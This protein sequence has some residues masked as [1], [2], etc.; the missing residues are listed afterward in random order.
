MTVC[1]A[2]NAGRYRASKNPD[3]S[4]TNSTMCPSCPL[5]FLS[6]AGSTKC[7]RCGA[8]RY[9]DGCQNCAKGQYRNGSDPIATS[10]RNCPTGYYNGDVGQGACLPCSPGEYNNV[11]GAKA[12]KQ[13]S[14]STYFSGKGRNS[15][16]IDC[17]SGWLSEVGSVKCFACGAGTF[18][19]GCKHCPLGYARTGTTNS[20]AT[21]CQQCKLGETTSTT[22]AAS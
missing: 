18:G 15:S 10:C 4:D 6:D 5:G 14:K 11:T 8:G 22:G 3:G 21:Q 13:C 9:G 12:C 1:Q 17:P 20:D 2:C 19:D 7:E 16:C